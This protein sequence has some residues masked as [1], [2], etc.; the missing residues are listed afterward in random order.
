MSALADLAL[1]EI[2]DAELAFDSRWYVE[3]AAVSN[4]SFAAQC[5]LGLAV[6]AAG[7]A[8][9]GVSEQDHLSQVITQPATAEAQFTSGAEAQAVANIAAM[10]TW[11]WVAAGG[12][13]WVALSEGAAAW[14]WNAAAVPVNNDEFGIAT[15][16]WSGGAVGQAFAHGAGLAVLAF[17]AQPVMQT[18]VQATS[19]SV[20][21]WVPQGR[22]SAVQSERADDALAFS[23]TAKAA[24]ARML[25]GA[26]QWAFA[27]TCRL[28]AWHNS[29]AQASW[30]F[31]GGAVGGLKSLLGLAGVD[32]MA[33]TSGAVPWP[34]QA[35]DAR[36][37]MGFAA[38]ARLSAVQGFDALASLLFEP[39]AAPG[40]SV[41]SSLPRAREGFV[42]PAAIEPWRVAPDPELEE[43]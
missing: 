12:G 19:A 16:S 25:D 24:S 33:F 6:Y 21:S 41:Y 27:A 38:T 20:W 15:W 3:V 14:S 18:L 17:S 28:Q 22:V 42:V 36:A 35:F 10:Q 39:I 32:Q 1:A 23:A 34:I 9:L 29:Q 7:S 31:T 40:N 13:Y 2:A 8:A 30:G 11:S 5:S 26:A 4:P 43:V 37:N